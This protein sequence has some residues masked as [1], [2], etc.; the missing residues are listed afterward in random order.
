MLLLGRKIMLTGWSKARNWSV[1]ACFDF[2]RCAPVRRSFD[3][4]NCD[5]AGFCGQLWPRLGAWL[6]IKANLRVQYGIKTLYDE[7]VGVYVI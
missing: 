7:T 4:K 1:T 6:W 3:S 5:S 2:K